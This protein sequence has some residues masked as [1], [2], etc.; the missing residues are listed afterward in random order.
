MAQVL[1]HWEKTSQCNMY[2]NQHNKDDIS[3]YLRYIAMG[4]QCNVLY[5]NVPQLILPKAS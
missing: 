5:K 4:T 1:Y 2:K 3:H